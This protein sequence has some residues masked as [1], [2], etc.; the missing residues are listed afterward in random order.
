MVQLCLQDQA[1]VALFKAEMQAIAQ[2]EQ[3]R[4]IDSS[5]ATQRDLKAVGATEPNMHSSGGLI[6]VDLEGNDGFGL[7]AVNLG[8]NDFDVAI[9]FSDSR[10]VDASRKFADLVVAR[11]K[12]HWPVSVVP[13][14]RG[15]L[16]NAQCLPSVVST[17]TG[18]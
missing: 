17:Q 2:G 8:L 15:A 5:F 6:S 3:L 12:T 14:G 10:P 11:L 16:P 9:G 13:T 7:T 4:Y 1:G 18:T